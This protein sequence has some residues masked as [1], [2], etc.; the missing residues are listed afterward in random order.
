MKRFKSH[1]GSIALFLGFFVMTG[2]AA[3]ADEITAEQF[4]GLI[5]LLNNI[6]HGKASLIAVQGDK[7]VEITDLA[8]MKRISLSGIKTTF[9][10]KN[11]KTG[12]KTLVA[13]Y[14]A[15]ETSKSLSR[16]FWKLICRSSGLCGSCAELF[17]ENL[18]K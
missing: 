9:Y 18:C 12:A 7:T 13:T 2:I 10:L 4:K 1:I 14:E 17:G 5:A 6:D 16:D 11:S 8:L 15:G 3:S